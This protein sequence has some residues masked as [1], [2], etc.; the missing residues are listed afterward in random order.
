[1]TD[2]PAAVLGAVL[3][4][5]IGGFFAYLAARVTARVQNR[6]NSADVKLRRIVQLETRV[7]KLES[8]DRIHQD[9]I[10]TLRQHITDGQPP[11]PP[12]WPAYE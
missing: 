4:A 3:G 6:Y 2:W 7:D 8:R 12:P 9:Y 11:P 1:M 10:E 5:L